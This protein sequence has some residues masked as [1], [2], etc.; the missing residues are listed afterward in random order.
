MSMSFVATVKTDRVT[1][2]EIET[3]DDVSIRG[4]NCVLVG[5][6]LHGTAYG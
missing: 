5:D 4:E 6:G 1:A 2:P 3:I